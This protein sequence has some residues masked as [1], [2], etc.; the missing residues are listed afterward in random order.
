MT[1]TP[2]WLL[3]LSPVGAFLGVLVGQWVTRKADRELGLRWRRE[4]TM[5]TMRWAAEKATD[6]EPRIADL[7]M[8]AL[9]ALSGS[10]LLQPEDEAFIEMVSKSLLERPVAEYRGSRG[11]PRTLEIDPSDALAGEAARVTG[12]TIEE[13]R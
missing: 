10:E 7:G 12:E 13:V 3:L 5:R 1:D 2:L 8:A 6:P 4:E 11:A 9:V